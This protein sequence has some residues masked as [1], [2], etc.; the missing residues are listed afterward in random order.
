[1]AFKLWRKKAQPI[2][3]NGI[4][5]QKENNDELHVNICKTEESQNYS[6]KNSSNIKNNSEENPGSSRNKESQANGIET[7]NRRDNYSEA[8]LFNYS[9]K[10]DEK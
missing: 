2:T 6:K 3:S 5:E 4:E 9:N 1:M 10:E 7:H 8:D